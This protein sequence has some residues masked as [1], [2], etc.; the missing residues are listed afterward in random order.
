MLIII[1]SKRKNPWN[2]QSYFFVFAH[3]FGSAVVGR[4]EGS[5]LYKPNIIYN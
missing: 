4:Y 2:V 5:N 3:E 1:I